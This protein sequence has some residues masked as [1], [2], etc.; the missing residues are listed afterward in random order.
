[1]QKQYLHNYSDRKP[2]TI[3]GWYSHSLNCLFIDTMS[4]GNAE[5][6]KRDIGV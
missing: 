2:S 3:V 1:M 4:A 5:P 6:Q